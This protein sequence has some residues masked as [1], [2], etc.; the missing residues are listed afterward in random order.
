[1]YGDEIRVRQAENRPQRQVQERL[2]RTFISKEDFH[3]EKEGSDRHIG[4]SRR[5]FIKRRSNCS[6]RDRKGEKK[7]FG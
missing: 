4:D 1:M 3:G 2:E 6:K 7:A 5:E